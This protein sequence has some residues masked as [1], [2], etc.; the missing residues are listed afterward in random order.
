[1]EYVTLLGYIKQMRGIV[2]E[3][4][5][6]ARRNHPA[7][8]VPLLQALREIAKAARLEGAAMLSEVSK[9]A[10]SL[11]SSL[12]GIA[13]DKGLKTMENVI[14]SEIPDVDGMITQ[15]WILYGNINELGD[16]GRPPGKSYLFFLT[17]Q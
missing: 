15:A 12:Q 9:V 3:L 13:I 5:I 2:L 6:P 14:D 11:K 10:V 1:M 7:Y 16:I 17:A 4:E 8:T